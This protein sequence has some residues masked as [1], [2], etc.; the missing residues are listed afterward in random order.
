[1]A[2]AASESPGSVVELSHPTWGD[3]REVNTPAR[4]S[5]EA[6]RCHDAAPA[7]GADTEH[8]LSEYLGYDGDRIAALRRNRVV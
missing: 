3:I 4:F 6:R 5:G 8:V 7:L 1:L 2:M